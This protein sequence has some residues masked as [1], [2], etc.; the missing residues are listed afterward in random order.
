[1][2]LYIVSIFGLGAGVL[3]VVSICCLRQSLENLLGLSQG[4][5]Y[6]KSRTLSAINENLILPNYFN[7]DKHKNKM[8]LYRS[9]S[10]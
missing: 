2:L 9:L 10:T 5:N 8:M 6:R 3:F 7:D 1:M 4:R